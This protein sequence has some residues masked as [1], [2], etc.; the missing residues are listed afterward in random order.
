VQGENAVLY[1]LPP[2]KSGFKKITGGVMKQ[3]NVNAENHG[4]VCM[5]P[6]HQGSAYSLRMGTHF[7]DICH[8]SGPPTTKGKNQWSLWP[9]ILIIS[10][11]PIFMAVLV[12]RSSSGQKIPHSLYNNLRQTIVTQRM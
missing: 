2:K 1:P 5:N 6:G 10:T 7:C 9:F 11:R 8:R 3:V 4:L 12:S